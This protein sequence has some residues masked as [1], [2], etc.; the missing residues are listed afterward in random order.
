MMSY[1][2]G[3][4]AAYAEEQK[5]RGRKNDPRTMKRI[6]QALSPYRFEV[7]TILAAIL[8]TTLLG[9]VGP[10]LIS[11][12]FDDAIQKG[13][14]TLLL[15]YVAIMAAALILSG[16]IGVGQ[17]Y[18]NNKVGQNVMY[19]F[20]NQLYQHL[21]SMPLSFFTGTRTGEIQSR[22]SN[23]VSGVEGAVTNTAT[24]LISNLSV[25]V[26]TIIAMIVISPLLTLI[27]LGLLPFFAWIT[28]KVGNVRRKI[29]N[30]TQ[31]SMASLTSQMEETLSVSGILLVKVVESRKVVPIPL[32]HK[33]V[34]LKDSTRANRR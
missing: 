26:S 25:V 32:S 16:I 30:E 13:N 31:K 8:I 4:S 9:L 14:A 11:H 23:D 15:I 2:G 34:P 22:L 33:V 20:R 29:S 7:V 10:L 5:K 1:R 21:Q 6:I 3:G 28:Y 12:V 24:S 27:T 18:L 17:A 19:D